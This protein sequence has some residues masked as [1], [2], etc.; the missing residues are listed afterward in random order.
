MKFLHMADMHFDAPFTVLNKK[1]NFGM[2]R[3]LDQREVFQKIIQYIQNN[4]I[5]YFFICGDFYEHETIQKSTIEF[6]NNL[7]QTIP[8]TKIFITPGNH[9]PYIKNS[10]YQTFPWNEN[11]KIFSSK[12][13]IVETKEA[14]IYGVGFDN[15]SCDTLG[16]QN[17]Q[18]QNPNKINILMTHGT[19]DGSSQTEL[20]YNVMKKSKL[21]TLGFDYIALGHI[22]K[23]DYQT[24]ENQNIVYPGATISHGF[25]ELGK[26]GVIVGNVEKNELQIQFVPMDNK[27]FQELEISVD[28]IFDIEALA[29]K[30]NSLSL[31]PH[32][33]YK[34]ILTG[35][36]KFEI[37]IS[38]LQKLIQ[39]E[40]ILKI[41]DKTKLNIDKNVLANENTLKGIFAKEILQEMQQQNYTKEQLEKAFEIGLSILS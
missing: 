26:H 30:L 16:I 25:D 15:F 33:F 23:P 20:P 41:K 8:T 11:V 37:S 4:Q 34:I 9:D 28:A 19:I 39:K 29:Q 1:G 40:A 12:L 7:F 6:I 17:I 36:R 21:K 18:I 32:I 35:N 14:N 3:R 31:S 22:H 5:E 38:T 13:E 27:E 10:M 2:L 24:E